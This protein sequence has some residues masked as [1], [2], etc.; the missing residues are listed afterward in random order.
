MRIG[1]TCG[2]AR[3]IGTRRSWI[4]RARVD[5]PPRP[6]SFPSCRE[7]TIF[8][9]TN[10]SRKLGDSIAGATEEEGTIIRLPQSRESRFPSCD[11][12][13]SASVSFTFAVGRKERKEGRKE[14][15][16]I[17]RRKKNADVWTRNGAAC[18]ATV[19]AGSRHCQSA[20]QCAGRSLDLGSAR[21]DAKC[22]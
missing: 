13:S 10:L 20:R 17:S 1:A 6:S 9:R 8:K 2:R 15:S 5:P 7:P 3:L 4:E 18:P 21:A 14:E 12:E 22:K 11:V 19:L 16:K